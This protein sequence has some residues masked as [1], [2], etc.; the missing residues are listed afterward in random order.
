MKNILIVGAG[1]GIGLACAEKLQNQNLFTVS[2]QETPE[3]SALKTEFRQCDVAK[4]D[5]SSLV[6]PEVLHGVIY[7]PGSITLKPF[8]RLS[9]QDF[10]DDFNQ[11]LVGAVKI[12]QL[13]LPALKKAQGSSVVL[14]STVA[15][16]LGM[17]FHS[18]V[19]ASKSAVEGLAKSL[20]AELALHKI[21]V[22]AIAPSLTDTALAAGLLSTE[23]KKTAA[24]A[25]H[26]LQRIGTPADIAALAAFLVLEESAWLTGQI[27][28]LD[29]GMGSIKS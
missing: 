2:R 29:G 13:C 10:L 23:E 6:L 1:R 17:P 15:A 16:K 8:Q 24:A 21:R 7:C 14:F 12:L 25:R 20:A 9:P 22:N 5:L 27:I 18:S 3:L 11:N 19:A 28:G 26:P 4:D